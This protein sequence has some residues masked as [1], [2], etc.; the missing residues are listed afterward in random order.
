VGEVLGAIEVLAPLHVACLE[1][2]TAA[3][4]VFIKKQLHLN[5]PSK[6]SLGFAPLHMACMHGN[7]EVALLLVD[8]DADVNLKQ[9]SEGATALLCVCSYKAEDLDATSSASALSVVEALVK[10]GA[11]MQWMCRILAVVL[12]LY[13]SLVLLGM[14]TLRFG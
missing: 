6:G 13:T 10:N 3:V 9:L 1:G 2:H 8:A 11:D 12:R 5:T 14:L 7:F 4:Q